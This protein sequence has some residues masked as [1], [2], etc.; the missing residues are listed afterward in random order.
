MLQADHIPICPSKS[1][2]RG[3]GTHSFPLSVFGTD[4]PERIPGCSLLRLRGVPV[5]PL[6]ATIAQ[7]YGNL[8][9]LAKHSLEDVQHLTVRHSAVG[10]I[11]G[12]GITDQQNVERPIFQHPVI[13]LGGNFL[14]CHQYRSTGFTVSSGSQTGLIGGRLHCRIK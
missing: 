13:T 9:I 3:I 1:I 6:A 7:S 2:R 8:H 12:E 11:L 10:R 14:L 4:N 5:E